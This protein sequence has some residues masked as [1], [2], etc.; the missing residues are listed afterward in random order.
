MIAV[1][2][3]TKKVIQLC[4]N[5]TLLLRNKLVFQESKDIVAITIAISDVSHIATLKSV[6]TKATIGKAMIGSK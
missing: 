3:L 1:K 4:D 5:S 2:E 6:R